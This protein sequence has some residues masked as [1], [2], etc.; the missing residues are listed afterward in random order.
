MANKNYLDKSGLA[1]FWSKIKAKFTEVSNKIGEKKIYYGT[2]DT[3]ASTAAKVVS[4]NNFVLETGAHISVRFTNANTFNG[5]ATLNVNNT[6]AVNIA[7][8]GTTLTTRYY[9]SAGEV[10]DFVYD[11]TNFVMVRTGTATT[12][13]YG[14]TKLATSAVSTSISTALTPASLNNLSLNMI[15][16]APLYS[17]SATYAVGDR[18]RYGYYTYKCITA[19][20]TAEAWTAAH[21]EALDPIQTQIDGINTLIG[22][23]ESILQNLNS[24]NGV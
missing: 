20:T 7:R 18:V 22:D 3:A 17:A 5:T 6:G 1:Y 24:G 8:V 16:G 11:G 12:S 21:W 15:S 13:Y 23:V 2:C 14:L 9:W 10:I 4:C 19:I